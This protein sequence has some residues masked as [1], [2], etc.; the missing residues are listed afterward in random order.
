MFAFMSGSHS[1]RCHDESLM[2]RSNLE[3]KKSSIFFI[4]TEKFFRNKER[5]AYASLV[6]LWY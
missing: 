1:F 4:K 3:K 2:V 6:L 5:C